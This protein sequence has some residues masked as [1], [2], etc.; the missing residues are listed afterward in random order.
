MKL[1][2]SVLSLALAG[3]VALGSGAAAEAQQRPIEP[4]YFTPKVMYSYTQHDE[5]KN[6]GMI[7]G[8]E[9]GQHGSVGKY[10]GG[11][12]HDETFGGGVSVGYDFG[13]YSEYPV[14]LELEYL[15][16][17]SADTNLGRKRTS[18][19]DLGNNPDTKVIHSQHEISSKVQTVMVNAFL[20]FPTDTAFTP[21]IGA[22]IG[23]AYVD[24]EVTSQRDMLL[25]GIE[26]HGGQYL[27]QAHHRYKGSDSSWN[28]AWQAS[29]GF[30]YQVADN[31]ALDLSYR[32]SDFGSSDI[33]NVNRTLH[34]VTDSSTPDAALMGEISNKS[35]LDLTAH[36]VLLGL[37]ISAF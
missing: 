17:G 27:Y 12:R 10:K 22:G 28:F 1:K 2:P 14:R 7:S 6:N 30:S 24:T 26:G 21:Y 13:A 31:M 11:D 33:G 16:H 9:L 5:F 15:H 32:Y 36:E 4:Y 18:N 25:G 23:T 35:T 29:A 20:D 3:A 8:P 34:G 37:R 19:I